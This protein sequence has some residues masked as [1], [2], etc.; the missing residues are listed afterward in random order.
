MEYQPVVRYGQQLLGETPLQLSLRGQRCLGIAA[1]AYACCHTKD[2]RVDGHHLPTPQH[3]ANNI[4]G[5]A[6]YALQRLQ[7]VGVGGHFAIELFH[8]LA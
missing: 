7:V 5:L 6:T 4:G 2:V 3:S 1:E 8:Y